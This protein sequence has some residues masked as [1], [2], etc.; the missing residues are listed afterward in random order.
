MSLKYLEDDLTNLYNNN[1][2]LVNS[3][4]TNRVL[5]ITKGSTISTITRNSLNLPNNTTFLSRTE[6]RLYAFIYIPDD[7]FYKFGIWTENRSARYGRGPPL[8]Q[9]YLNNIDTVILDQVNNPNI[10]SYSNHYVLK[11]G[12]Y[13]LTIIFNPPNS[14]IT[15]GF[16]L[17]YATYP[18]T[19]INP[20]AEFFRNQPPNSLFSMVDNLLLNC[21]TFINTPNLLTEQFLLPTLNYCDG[22]QINNTE[23]KE[24]FDVKLPNLLI[25]HYLSKITDSDYPKPVNGMYGAWTI[26]DTNWNLTVDRNNCGANV[27][28]SRTRNYL[29]PLH[30]GASNMSTPHISDTKTSR[31]NCYTDQEIIDVWNS[32]GSPEPIIPNFSELQLLPF[33]T[34]YQNITDQLKEYI[35]IRTELIK[36]LKIGSNSDVTTVYKDWSINN[37]SLLVST[38]GLRSGDEILTSNTNIIYSNVYYSNGYTWSNGDIRLTI[39]ND[40]N[41]VCYK[42]ILNQPNVI[43]WSS[44]TINNPNAR[45]FIQRNGGQLVIYSETGT[46][47]WDYALS[48]KDE[49]SSALSPYYAVL[50]NTARL[51]IINSNNIPI[52]GN[53][54]HIIYPNLC[55]HTSSNELNCM[56]WIN[57]AFRL[58]FVNGFLKFYGNNN[59][60]YWEGSNES[61]INNKLC[62][63][64]VNGSIN[65]GTELVLNNG[66]NTMTYKFVTNSTW[67]INKP[68][69]GTLNRWNGVISEFGGFI[70]TDISTNSLRTKTFNNSNITSSNTLYILTQK[71]T[72]FILGSK[73][74]VYISGDKNWKYIDNE[75]KYTTECIDNN[76]HYLDSNGN[77]KSSIINKV[78]LIDE[79]IPWCPTTIST[80]NNDRNRTLCI[81]PRTIWGINNILHIGILGWQVPTTDPISTINDQGR[82]IDPTTFLDV[83]VTP[84]KINGADGGNCIAPKTDTDME[85]PVSGYEIPESEL[86]KLTVL[87]YGNGYLSSE[88]TRAQTGWARDSNRPAVSNLRRWDG[89]IQTGRGTEFYFL[90]WKQFPLFA[91]RNFKCFPFNGENK[92]GSRVVNLSGNCSGGLE[93]NPRNWIYVNLENTDYTGYLRIFYRTCEDFITYV[94]TLSPGQISNFTNKQ[95]SK[96]A[97]KLSI[98]IKE[99]F[100]SS[101]CNLENILTDKNCNTTELKLYKQYINSMNNYCKRE[102]KVTNDL[103]YDFVNE[104]FKYSDGEILQ[105]DKSNKLDLITILEN[106]CSNKNY[107]ENDNCLSINISKP[108]IIQK[109]VNELKDSKNEKDIALYKSLV[110]KYGNEFT[111]QECL[112]NILQDKCTPLYQIDKY[113]TKLTEE[114]NKTCLIDSNINHPLCQKYNKE[115]PEQLKQITKFC[116]KNKKNKSCITFYEKYKTDKD[117]IKTELYDEMWWQVNG[118]WVYLLIGLISILLLGGG[119]KYFV[120]RKKNNSKQFEE[121]NNIEEQSS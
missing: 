87:N 23:C 118:W 61:N 2:C 35:R 50:T 105:I 64:S 76:W 41:L 98:S 25:D 113:K 17:D 71:K 46:L 83:V 99:N 29:P 49:I 26:D 110:E 85:D 92:C 63:D 47:L 120:K 1:N 90:F 116:K 57:G 33:Q 102:D 45:L 42:Q 94:N 84:N 121:S 19:N 108:E 12:I 81:R 60:Q 66:Y 15:R 37:T 86:K 56:Q 58:V 8:C 97:N 67:V 114:K 88:L 44:N 96:F 75:N 16:R 80:N 30:G 7:A 22:T 48:N 36:N 78:T 65:I 43:L 18:I 111:Y 55:Y 11:K 5:S 24:F 14:N 39:Q 100:E 9:I 20:D 109:Q 101:K 10:S 112:N 3:T 91:N 72:T 13:L 70:L 69:G 95:A 68:S 77:P 34:N 40:G 62:I 54:E 89:A 117:F 52:Y 73:G 28:K 119:I 115:N 6:R 74:Y 53:E 79:S 82:I 21:N 103:C 32:L 59:I 106:T 51:S 31:I 93:F 107:W 27:T 38:L 4:L 104:K